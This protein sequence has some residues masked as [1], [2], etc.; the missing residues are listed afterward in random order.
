MVL[1]RN[2]KLL[3]LGR[4]PVYDIFVYRPSRCYNKYNPACK[5]L[6]FYSKMFCLDY[7]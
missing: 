6:W 3:V 1:V 4:F 2:R 7:A 5:N